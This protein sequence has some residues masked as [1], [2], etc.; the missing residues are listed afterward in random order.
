M[1]NSLEFAYVEQLVRDLDAG[2]VSEKTVPRHD[3][4]ALCRFAAGE[5]RWNQFVTR[6][7][8][9]IPHPTRL[10]NRRRSRGGAAAAATPTGGKDGFPLTNPPLGC[11]GKGK[12]PRIGPQIGLLG[13]KSGKWRDN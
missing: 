3:F 2:G 9:T 13:R 5:E 4:N 6:V 8:N 11:V 7:L 10:G 12:R 1:D